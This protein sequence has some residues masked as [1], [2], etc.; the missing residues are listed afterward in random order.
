MISEV[1]LSRLSYPAAPKMVTK[2]PGPKT[3]KLILESA[4]YEALTRGGGTFP[5][6]M[7]E[8]KG[9]TIKDADGRH[10]A[11]GSAGI[12]QDG[13][14][15]RLCRIDLVVG[16]VVPNVIRI[17][18]AAKQRLRTLNDAERLLIPLRVPAE[19][20]DRLR[21]R[22]RHHNLVM[23]RIHGDLMRGSRQQSVLALQN[24]ERIINA[25]LRFRRTGED[26]DPRLALSVRREDFFALGVVSQS[27]PRKT[28]RRSAFGGGANDPQRRHISGGVSRIHR[29]RVIQPVANP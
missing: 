17:P 5:I 12:Y 8:G 23:N 21:K 28:Q 7:E 10:I 16:L 11:A 4:K 15:I 13:L 22:I 27:L 20:Q 26:R 18:V 9:S 19:E 29:R 25:L 24:S 14:A 3:Q 6:I 1:E 2:V